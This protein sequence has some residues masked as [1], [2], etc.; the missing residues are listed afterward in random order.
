MKL[1][2]MK[3]SAN[4]V[5]AGDH[6]EGPDDDDSEDDQADTSQGADVEDDG[7]HGGDQDK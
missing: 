2:A 5:I 1:M 7:A 4:L 6:L 3:L